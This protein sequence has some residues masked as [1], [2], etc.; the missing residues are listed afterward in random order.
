V[1]KTQFRL[2]SANHL[3]GWQNY[4]DMDG[5]ISEIYIKKNDRLR[6]LP[7]VQGYLGL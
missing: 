5:K 3:L 4:A 1:I 6:E 7:V 2:A